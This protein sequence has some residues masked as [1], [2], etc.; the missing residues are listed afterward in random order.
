MSSDPHVLLSIL[1]CPA[2]RAQKGLVPQEFAERS[3]LACELCSFW[4]PIVDEVIVLLTP[5]RNP[6]GLRRPVQAAVP[7]RLE[8]RPAR[9]VDLKALIYSFYGRMH[10]FGSEFRLDD[11][12]LVVDVGCSTG[13]LAALLRPDQTYVG[14]DLFFKSLRFARRASGQFFVQ[15]DAERLPIK[16]HSVPFF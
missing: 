2:C 13:S 7:L 9:F 3:Y 10:E 5:E 1:D 16:S 8:R 6:R 15:A 14:F 12:S 4:Y 11:E